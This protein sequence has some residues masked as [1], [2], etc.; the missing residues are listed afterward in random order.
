M[1]GLAGL[2]AVVAGAMVACVADCFPRYIEALETAAGLLVIGGFAV[3][4]YA[5]TTF[6]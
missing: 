1:I 5:L 3:A 6:I 2:L 4:G